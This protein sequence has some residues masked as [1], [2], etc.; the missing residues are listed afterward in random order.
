MLVTLDSTSFFYHSP[1]KEMIHTS[2]NQHYSLAVHHSHAIQTTVQKY[3]AM[4]QFPNNLASA[5]ATLPRQPKSTTS[6]TRI[7]PNPFQLHHRTKVM[8]QSTGPHGSWSDQSTK[9]KLERQRK[10]F[11]E[12]KHS[13]GRGYL[14]PKRNTGCMLQL[15][16]ARTFCLQLPHQTEMHQHAHH[17]THW[18]ESRRQ[19]KRL[20]HHYGRLYLPTIKCAPKRRSGRADD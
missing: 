17:A 11:T 1:L 6:K 13:Q 16:W 9:R 18:L 3:H 8:E 5:K 12:R 14:T 10:R 4:K 15:Q 20:W 7:W 2:S 19:R